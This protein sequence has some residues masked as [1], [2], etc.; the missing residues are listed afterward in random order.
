M[1]ALLTQ[2]AHLI[3]EHNGGGGLARAAEH[4]AHERLALSNEHAERLHHTQ[5][6]DHSSCDNGGMGVRVVAGM[7]LSPKD[8]GAE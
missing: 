1:Q 6:V 3:Q 2:A 4:V 5:K 8:A 7:C